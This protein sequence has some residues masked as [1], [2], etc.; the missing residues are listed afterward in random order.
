MNADVQPQT[1]HGMRGFSKLGHLYKHSIKNQDKKLH[2]E[3]FWTSF[4]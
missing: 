4:I 3:K 1:F 2:L